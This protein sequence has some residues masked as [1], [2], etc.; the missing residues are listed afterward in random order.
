[1][2]LHS[3]LVSFYALDFTLRFVLDTQHLDMPAFVS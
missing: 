1:M 2:A 3:E